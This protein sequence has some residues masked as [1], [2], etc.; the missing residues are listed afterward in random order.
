MPTSVHD[1]RV[2]VKE[3]ARKY[4]NDLLA[5]I[6]KQIEHQ[7]RGDNAVS[8]DVEETDDFTDEVQ[9][10]LQGAYGK[11]GWKL[12]LQRRPAGDIILVLKPDETKSRSLKG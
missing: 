5:K 3:R 4:W 12:D 2:R 1:A 7:F 8:V 11:A 10:Q 6:D 9:L